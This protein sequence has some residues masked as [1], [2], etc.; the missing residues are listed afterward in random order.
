MGHAPYRA[1][2]ALG[3]V[4]CALALAGLA[5]AAPTPSPYDGGPAL[6]PLPVLAQLPTLPFPVPTD[7]SDV[8]IDSAALAGDGPSPTMAASNYG[9]STGGDDSHGGGSHGGGPH[10]LVVDDDRTECPSAPFTSI[11]A[12]VDAAAPG[13]FIEVCRGTYEEEVTIPAGKD[14]L[15]IFGTGFLDVSIKAPS[16]GLATTYQD[17]VH[18]AGAKN[19]TLINVVVTGPFS[20][21]AACATPF[22]GV[23]VDGGGSIGLFGDEVTE[24]RAA[25]EALR[26]CQTGVAVL[27]GRASTGQTGSAEIGYDLVDRY[28]KGGIVVDNL[29]STANV[30]HSLVEGIGTTLVTAQNGIQISRGATATLSYNRVSGNSYGN[31][32]VAAA[33]GVLLYQAGKVSTRW[34]DTFQ[35]NVGIWISETNDSLVDGNYAHDQISYDGLYVDELSTDNTLSRNVSRRN[36][37]YDCADDS[38]GT[39]TA[40][41]ANTWTKDVGDTE[42]K[43]GLCHSH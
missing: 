1:A 11:Q 41:T 13:S 42:N 20:D 26:G 29:G 3:I 12:A 15:T 27:V 4:V 34:N 43:P 7:L 14:G 28:Q 24:I 5:A 39:K 22:A 2:A 16:A 10:V 30:H 18:V 35:N 37:E 38:V 17:V 19:V 8:G 40:G 25:D 9:H 31:P 6:V 32:D 21:L 23:R 36:E 33:G